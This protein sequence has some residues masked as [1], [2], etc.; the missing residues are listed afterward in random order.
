M[1]KNQLAV[2]SFAGALFLVLYF[3]FD[4]RPKAQKKINKESQREA[5]IETRKDQRAR[6]VGTQQSAMIDQKKNDLL[7]INFE[8]QNEGGLEI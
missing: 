8:N 3:G 6:I 2:L 5:D 4:T 7:P 1:S